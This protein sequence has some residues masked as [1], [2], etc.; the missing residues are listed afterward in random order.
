MSRIWIAVCLGAGALGAP[1]IA[2]AQTPSGAP[3]ATAVERAVVVV[4]ADS[5]GPAL[6][7]LLLELLR[8]RDIDTTFLEQRAFEREQLL[9]DRAASGDGGRVWVFVVVRSSSLVRLYFRAPG[10]DRF[11]LRDVTVP[12][13]LDELGRE[14]VGQV[15]E[16]GVDALLHQGAGMTRAEVRDVLAHEASETAREAPE[17]ARGAVPEPEP[18]TQPPPPGRPRTPSKPARSTP[19]TSA[20]R[21]AGWLAARYDAAWT[22]SSFGMAHGPS[23]ELGAELGARHLVRARAFGGFRLPQHLE[24]PQ[25]GAE[26]T[27]TSWRAL[28]DL[29]TR[30]GASALFGSVGIGQDLARVVPEA[31]AG[32]GVTA[33][34]AL[35]A[36]T[37]V[38]RFEV[39]FETG[40]PRFRVALIAG[41]DTSL[42]DTHYDV[43]EPSGRK[44][45]AEPWPVRPGLAVAVAWQP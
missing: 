2:H 19:V 5:G 18:R 1:A 39:R 8:R 16:S 29:G 43:A 32:S 35:R 11:L 38:A 28:V 13:G 17:T 12:D 36:N 33:A 37:L 22:G 6:E 23:F 40:S 10:A 20:P 26:L 21:I 24:T 30:A 45:V 4:V 41:A 15:V 27:T 25:I 7:A 3:D 31:T 14:L 44:R 34:G 9:D 42:A